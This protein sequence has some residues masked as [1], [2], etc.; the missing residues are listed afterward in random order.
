MTTLKFIAN[1]QFFSGGCLSKQ[2]NIVECAGL[3]ILEV[4]LSIHQLDTEQEAARAVNQTFSYFYVLRCALPAFSELLLLLLSQTI[5]NV[6]FLG[7][8]F[9]SWFQ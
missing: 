9:L 3:A 1:F 4:E 5:A 7:M 8:F 2:L 6:C